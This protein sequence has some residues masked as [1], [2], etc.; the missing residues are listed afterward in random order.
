MID[1]TIAAFAASEFRNLRDRSATVGASE[2]GNCIRRTWYA[3]HDAPPEGG[4]SSWG[5]AARGTLLEQYLLVPALR[6]KFEERLLLA[7][8][9]Q[10]TFAANEL[11]ATP[12]G[13]LVDLE[14]D[15]LA[16]LGLPDNTTAIVVE[17]KTVDPRVMLD[18]PKPEHVFQVQAQMG[19]VRE[20]TNHQPSHAVLIYVNAADL[21]AREFTVAFDP[22]VFITAQRR[23]RRIMTAAAAAEL[24]PEGYITGG[25]ECEYCPFRGPC[26]LARTTVP[27]GTDSKIDPVA[28]AEVSELG[29]G[30][31]AFDRIAD[32]AA[33]E[34]RALKELLRNRLREL[35]V[36]RVSGDGISIIWSQVKGRTTIDAGAMRAAGI[37]PTQFEKLGAPS[38]RLLIKPSS[39]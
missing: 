8:D 13:L 32:Q 17:F 7:G 9:D 4:S 27:A 28:V 20:C 38:D 26:G 15:E 11:S 6:S 36:R 30:I 29:K 3:K 21:S 37:D 12:D 14:P 22:A 23:A 31:L 39:T 5:P 1:A 19:L 25:R 18:E 24:Q 34:A 33:T 10:C 2:V 16:A 35:D